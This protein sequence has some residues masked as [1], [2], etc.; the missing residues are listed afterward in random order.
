MTKSAKAEA[1]IN[2]RTVPKI[3]A[4]LFEL[5]PATRYI[6]AI[7]ERIEIIKAAKIGET[8]NN[9]KGTNTANTRTTVIII[10]KRL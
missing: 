1:K 9:T 4:L 7:V 2:D 8:L 3:A 6:V 5:T 10:D